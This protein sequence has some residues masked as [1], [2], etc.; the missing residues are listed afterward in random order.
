MQE[1]AVQS[2][3]QETVKATAVGNVLYEH[4]SAV[5]QLL[6]LA[7]EYRKSHENTLF[8][9]LKKHPFFVSFDEKTGTLTLD[10]E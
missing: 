8:Q 3:E 7:A 10:I 2:Y 1:Q 5:T 9:Q 6:S 4:Y